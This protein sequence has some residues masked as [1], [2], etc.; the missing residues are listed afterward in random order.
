MQRRDY[1]LPLGG[2]RDGAQIWSIFSSEETASPRALELLGNGLEL[3]AP[4]G[5]AGSGVGRGAG[6]GCR[7][8]VP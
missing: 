5:I 7:G 3:A 4:S 6:E 2:I 8:G 1:S